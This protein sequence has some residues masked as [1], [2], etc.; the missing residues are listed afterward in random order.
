[1]V[2]HMVILD[3]ILDNELMTRKLLNLSRVL[4]TSI[5]HPRKNT[6]LLVNSFKIDK[7]LF[8]LLLN[9]HHIHLYQKATNY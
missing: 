1:M 9:I 3:S 4:W 6:V 7:H 2:N 5:F 8:R